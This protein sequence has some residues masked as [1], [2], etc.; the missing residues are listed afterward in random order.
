MTVQMVRLSCKHCKYKIEVQLSA[1]DWAKKVIFKH[2][3]RKHPEKINETNQNAEAPEGA[4][5]EVREGRR[6]GGAPFAAAAATDQQEGQA[7]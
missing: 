1:E 6:E 3:Q 4:A 7:P 2:Y 5:Q